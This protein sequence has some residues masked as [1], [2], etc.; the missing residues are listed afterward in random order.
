MNK[1]LLPVLLVFC[2]AGAFAQ[3][4]TVT[5]TNDKGTVEATTTVQTPAEKA[6][7]AF[8]LRQTGSHLLKVRND[9]DGTVEC[10]NAPG[11]AYTRDD[12]DHT[13]ATTTAG[14]LRDLD[15]SIT[16]RHPD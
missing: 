10:A 12:I 9:R 7:D 2:T 16:I 6:A 8:C 15:P 4:G 5:T 3:S 14:A 1:I 11:R 13:G